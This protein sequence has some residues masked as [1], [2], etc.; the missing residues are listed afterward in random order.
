ML[1]YKLDLAKEPEYIIRFWRENPVIAANHLLVRDG[2]PLTLAPIQ[3]VILTEWWN[4][5]FNLLTASRGSGKAL[6]NGTKVLTPSGWVNIENFKVGDIVTTPDGNTSEVEGVFPQGVTENYKI[7]FRDGRTATC[8]KDH[9]WTVIGVGGLGQGS[10]TE[11]QTHRFEDIKNYFET[12]AKKQHQSIRIPLAEGLFKGIENKELPINPYLLGVLIGDGNITHKINFSS[13]DKFI[14]DKVSKIIGDTFQ[15]TKTSSSKYDYSITHAVPLSVK[16]KRNKVST[17]TNLYKEKLVDLNLFGKKSYE[18][19]IPEE[20]MNLSRDQTLNLIQGLFDTDATVGFSFGRGKKKRSGNNVSYCT[21]SEKLAKQ[22]QH[23][24][25]KLG[26][27]ALISIRYP[28]FTYKGI[29]KE[30]RKAYIVNIRYK[31]KRELFSVPKKLERLNKEDQYSDNLGLQ[32]V[33]IEPAGKAESTCIKIK[34]PRGLFVIDGYVVTHNTFTCA[35]YIALRCLLYPGTRIGIFAPAFRQS[36]LIFNEFT[37]LFNE[38]PLL[39]QC[40]VKEPV[41]QNDQCICTFRSIGKGRMPSELLALPVGTDGGKIRGLRLKV[42]IMDEIPHIPESIFRASIHPM[43]STAVNPMQTV[44]KIEKLKKEGNFN[45]VA[46]LASG[47]AG[48]IGITSGYYQFNY[49]WKEM[50]NFWEHIQ[51]GSNNYNLRFIPYTELPEGFYNAAVVED[52]RLNAPHHM[53]VTEWLAEWIADSAGAFAM[54]M[55][56]SCRDVRCI[57]KFSRDPNTDKGKEFIL[58]IDPA[59]ERDSTG[60]VVTELGFPNKVIFIAE[61]EEKPFPEQAKYIFKLIQAYNPTLIYMDSG[62]GGGTLRDLLADP[63]SLGYPSDLKIIDVDSP[64]SSIGKRILKLCNF[65]PEFIEDANNEAKLLLE[66]GSIKFPT[67]SNPIEVSRKANASDLTREVDLVQ[68]MINQIASVTVTQTSTGKLHYDLP[69]K[70]QASAKTAD[71]KDLYTAF[72]LA[73]K[74]IY[75]LQYKPRNDAILIEKGVIKEVTPT[76]LTSSHSSNIINPRQ[77]GNTIYNSNSGKTIIPGGGI[78]IGRNGNRKR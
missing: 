22:V 11:W 33:K 16:H 28:K 52:A 64:L 74:C 26:G 46:D 36:K 61:L 29:K 24:I 70:S 43:M 9:L 25:W 21:T 51:K 17:R 2:E 4:S 3:Q 30:G 13:A 27:C 40:V 45:A 14:V 49:W 20:Y 7:T 78:V 1:K 62:G 69:K 39:Q 48:Y 5:K 31:N 32:I 41:Q 53:F 35:V 12:K 50:V 38:S 57:P 60:I 37:R 71:K 34:D 15:V 73:C 72:I 76:I 18:K 59:R 55:L 54:S 68:E 19:F 77:I 47:D 44:K 6:L 67:A 63:S 65:N 58:S 66:Q 75:D 23:L 42:V 56:E 10:P 8:C